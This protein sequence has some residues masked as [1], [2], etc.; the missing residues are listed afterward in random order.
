MGFDNALADRKTEPGASGRA[1]ARLIG[2]VESLKNSRQIL[3]RYARTIVGNRESGQ[4]IFPSDPDTNLTASAVVH[5]RI[6]EEIGDDLG[7]AIRITATLT[8]R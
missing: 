2:P 6:R 3:A 1:G 7:K 4:S 5:D 8:R